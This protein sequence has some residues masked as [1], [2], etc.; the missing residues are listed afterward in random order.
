MHCSDIHNFFGNILMFGVFFR[1]L[2]VESQGLLP[3]PLKVCWGCVSYMTLIEPYWGCRKILTNFYV[4]I[5][6]QEPRKRAQQASSKV[7]AKVWLVQ[8]LDLQEALLTWSTIPSRES[9]G[10]I[11]SVCVGA[12]RRW[13]LSRCV[14][15][16]VSL[17]CVTVCA[18]AEWIRSSITHLCCLT[19]FFRVTETSQDVI[20]L[21][22]PRFIHEDGV[23]RPYK[24]REGIG[25]QM[26]QVENVY[27]YILLSTVFQG[28]SAN[29]LTM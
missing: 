23:I 12:G 6:V 9:R 29:N 28:K 17:F 20:S 22:P 24:E 2:S 11:I 13:C 8:S 26:L 15:L 16:C 25:S 4:C 5:V 14:F 27:W 10:T 7:L 19:M 1:D 3:N 18:Y 21:R